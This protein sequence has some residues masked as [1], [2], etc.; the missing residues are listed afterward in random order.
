VARDNSDQ[1]EMLSEAV[2]GSGH[3]WARSL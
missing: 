2:I 3:V 1:A